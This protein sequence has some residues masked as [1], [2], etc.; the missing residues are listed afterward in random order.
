LM[1]REKITNEARLEDGGELVWVSNDRPVPL[2]AFRDA[3][4]S[5]P[6]NQATAIDKS[7]AAFFKK[8]RESQSDKMSEEDLFEARA[9][10]APGTVLVN[11]VTG[12]E[13]VL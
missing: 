13:T 12:R 7:N 11:V 2:D 1:L 3:F 6:A 4:M 8:Y 9:N 10:H 5:P